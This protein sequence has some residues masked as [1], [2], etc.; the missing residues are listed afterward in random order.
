MNSGR[1]YA[2]PLAVAAALDE[3]RRC[4]G[5]QFDAAIVAALCAVVELGAVSPRGSAAP[6]P[7]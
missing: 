6:R 2:Q 1:P 7:A 4:A 3:L 5:S